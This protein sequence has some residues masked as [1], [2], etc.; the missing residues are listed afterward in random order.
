M[1]IYVVWP[2]DNSCPNHQAARLNP[3]PPPK[4][5]IQ[6]CVWG[7]QEPVVGE[8]VFILNRQNQWK[9]LFF[10][11]RNISFPTLL[12]TS[13][14]T[15]LFFIYFLLQRR[16]LGTSSPFQSTRL[17]SEFQTLD[18]ALFAVWLP[19]QEVEF[20]HMETKVWKVPEGTGSNRGH[21]YGALSRQPAIVVPGFQT[22][23]P[24]QYE[25]LTRVDPP[26]HMETDETEEKLFWWLLVYRNSCYQ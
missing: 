26:W 13:I 16:V 17:Q 21:N 14:H 25:T 2:D 7:N 3:P 18:V 12:L 6:T 11:P 15:H 20:T 5:G 4:S 19:T 1:L 22:L 23:S 8:P 10:P 9:T 24:F